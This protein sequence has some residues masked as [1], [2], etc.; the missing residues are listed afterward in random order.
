MLAVKKTK[1]ECSDIP[2]GAEVV[3]FSRELVVSAKHTLST[4]TS[5]DIEMKAGSFDHCICVK[6]AEF[7]YVN[8]DLFQRCITVVEKA[9]TRA[10]M[11]KNQISDVVLAGRSTRIPRVRVLLTEFFDGRAPL[12]TVNP[13]EVV[14]YGVAVQAGLL[15]RKRAAAQAGF[16]CRNDLAAPILIIQAITAHSIGVGGDLGEMSVIIPKGSPIPTIGS[17]ELAMGKDEQTTVRFNLYE[18]DRHFCVHN[19]LLGALRL[20]S[21]LDL[22]NSEQ[23]VK[24]GQK[25]KVF[26]EVDS[27]GI[28]A[29]WLEEGALQTRPTRVVSVE[30]EWPGL[31]N[32]VQEEE[33]SDCPVCHSDDQALLCSKWNKTIG[34]QVSL[35]VQD[36]RD[37]QNSWNGNLTYVLEEEK[38]ACEGQLKDIVGEIGHKWRNIA[39]AYLPPRHLCW[40]KAS[41]GQDDTIMHSENPVVSTVRHVRRVIG[42]LTSTEAADSTHILI[43]GSAALEMWNALVKED[44]IDGFLFEGGFRDPRLVDKFLKGGASWRIRPGGAAKVLLL[45]GGKNESA[46]FGE[47][48]RVW[49]STVTEEMMGEQEVI[50]ITTRYVPTLAVS[51][52]RGMIME[53]DGSYALLSRDGCII[54]DYRRMGKDTRKVKIVPIFKTDKNGQ[55]QELAEALS[56]LRE[57]MTGE[58]DTE[59]AELLLEYRP[60]DGV[61]SERSLIEDIES[62]HAH[63]RRRVLTNFGPEAAQ[64]MRIVCSLE[65]GLASDT[66]RRITNLPHVNGVS[67]RLSNSRPNTRT[68]LAA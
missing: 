57:K 31:Y 27:N 14:A 68:D 3:P 53:I 37:R 20:K 29:A 11:N 5:T 6:R 58:T 26:L 48:Q 65:D 7:E 28:L 2:D 52:G 49:L 67:L 13:D 43:A 59:W 12:Q 4:Y 10:G 41:P 47:S 50:W 63:I 35:A 66:R 51:S 62:A 36:Y 60:A 25:I 55:G 18:G 64:E 54:K 56:A 23:R 22:S 1:L 61:S 38:R 39:V 45:C 40:A 42:N 19:K 46:T 16:L 30:K 8:E 33:G 32:S 9:L 44:E 17:W 21:P 24:R 15:C 34:C